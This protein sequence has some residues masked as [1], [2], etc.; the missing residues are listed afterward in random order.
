MG[1]LSKDWIHPKGVIDRVVTQIREKSGA[2]SWSLGIPM[3]YAEDDLDTINELCKRVS[4]FRKL[5]K[6]TIDSYKQESS[7]K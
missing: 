7:F 2:P 6:V 3:N 5:L 1:K 4:Q